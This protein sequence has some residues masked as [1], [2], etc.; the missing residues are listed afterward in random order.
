MA[1]RVIRLILC[2][3]MLLPFPVYADTHE[4]ASCSV[5]D[6]TTALGAAAE[7][8]TVTVPAGECTWTGGS[9]VTVSTASI[10]LQGAGIASTIITHDGTNGYLLSLSATGVTVTG[11]AFLGS[12]STGTTDN[13]IKVNTSAGN[14]RITNCDFNRG[15]DAYTMGYSIAIDGVYGVIDN[16]TFPRVANETIYV[17]GPCD[18]WQT[19]SSIGG[20]DNVFVENCY[21]KWVTG[22]GGDQLF[23]DCNADSR[24]VVRYCDIDGYKFDA[25]GK[26]SNMNSLCDPQTHR[27]AR[28]YEVYNN[29]WT[30]GNL[31]RMAELRG[32]TGVFYNNTIARTGS[33]A[34]GACWI[35]LQDYAY[36]QTNCYGYDPSCG[37]DTDY[38]LDD[39]IGVGVDPK[40]AGSEPLYVWNNTE[41]GSPI[42]VYLVPPDGTCNQVGTC[43]ETLTAADFFHEDTDYVLSAKSGY[44][45]YTC[46]H[47]RT[48]LSGTCSPSIAGRGG[49]NLSSGITG[50]GS[51]GSATMGGSGTIT[52]TSP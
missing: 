33:N 9:G 49:Y 10:T 35:R 4:A 13:M 11:F 38:P 26:C 52:L 29:A 3:L 17:K 46:P 44:S 23:T 27:S 21:F 16:C 14:F 7:G 42:T 6:I 39:Q 36:Q 31:Q 20:A 47:P 32:G 40:S 48:G 41:N 51:G 34:S 15:G 12:A 2:F 50:I 18:S 25:H 1:H 30:L 8:D 19:A 28:H 43:G 22:Y 5:A 24:V 45:A 37:C